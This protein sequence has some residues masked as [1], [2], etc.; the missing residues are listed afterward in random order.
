M[1]FNI[2]ASKLERWVK[3][4]EGC[5]IAAGI[6]P[7]EKPKSA[8]VHQSLDPKKRLS[9]ESRIVVQQRPVATE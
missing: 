5:Y 9:S 1:N 7:A 2:T 4:E 6:A 3:Q 8:A